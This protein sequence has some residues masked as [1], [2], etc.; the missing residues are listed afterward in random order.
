MKYIPGYEF[1][2][3]RKVRDFQAN[4]AYKIYYIK[5]EAEKVT[6][7]FQVETNEGLQVV[8]MDFK[9]VGEAETL[10]TKSLGLKK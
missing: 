6:Y 7:Q 8:S 9:S 5:P 3:G 4:C 1:V 10:I 2:V